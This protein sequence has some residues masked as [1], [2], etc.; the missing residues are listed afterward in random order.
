MQATKAATA[1]SQPQ[2]GFAGE[3]AQRQK[4]LPECGPPQSSDSRQTVPFPLDTDQIRKRGYHLAPEAQAKI[5]RIREQQHFV[6][7]TARSNSARHNVTPM[8]SALASCHVPS[9]LRIPSG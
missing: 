7:A 4:T 1:R 8:S 6:E 5:A 9:A 3:V 2:L